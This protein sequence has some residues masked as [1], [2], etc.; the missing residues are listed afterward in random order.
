MDLRKLVQRWAAAGLL[1]GLFVQGPPSLHAQN[2][3]PLPPIGS[4]PAPGH[5]LPSAAQQPQLAPPAPQLVPPPASLILPALPPATA[6]DALPAA[7][8]DALPP[9]L[10]ST[11]APA[12]AA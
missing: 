1:A 6:A 7:P 11:K 10:P 3:V 2:S 9:S 8:P 4:V 5:P 12:T